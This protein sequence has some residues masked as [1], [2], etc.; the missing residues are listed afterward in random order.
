MK[1]EDRIDEGSRELVYRKLD[2]QICFHFLFNIH[3]TVVLTG[4]T[5]KTKPSPRANSCLITSLDYGGRI[6]WN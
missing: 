2:P 4:F 5:P 3:H 1:L 6:V